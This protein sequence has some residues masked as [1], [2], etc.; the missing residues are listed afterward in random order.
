MSTILDR[1]KTRMCCGAQFSKAATSYIKLKLRQ[2]RN[3]KDLEFCFE[4]NEC[5]NDDFQK[6]VQTIISMNLEAVND[7]HHHI[8]MQAEQ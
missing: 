2:L 7:H 1:I 5:M 8:G 3:R 6:C 4:W